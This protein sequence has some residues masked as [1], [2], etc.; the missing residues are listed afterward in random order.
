MKRRDFIRCLGSLALTM[1][2]S[3]PRAQTSSRMFRV[4]T[5]SPGI[6]MTESVYGPALVR[7]LAQHGY[8]VGRNLIIETRAAEGHLERIPA[9]I[10]DL[11]ANKVDVMVVQGYPPALAA[12]QIGTLPTVVL[13]GTGDPV[14]T[15]LIASLARPGGNIT[16]ISDVS[17]QLSPK[18]LELLKDLIPTL[19]QVA[20][21][22]NA[23]D[24]GMTLRVRESEQAARALN[25]SVQ[26]LGVREP[27]DFAAAFAAMI[28][29]LPDGILMV[30][31][32]LTLLNRRRV[33]EFSAAHRLPAIYE[34]EA[35]VRDGGLM[36]YGPDQSGSAE[37]GAALVD[38]IL[39][40]ASPAELPFENPTRFIFAI[41]LKTAK[42]LGITVPSTLLVQADVLIE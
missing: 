6:P 4:G 2:S 40:G 1:G 9:L 41:N 3:G 18:R 23:N 24:L 37:R 16:G 14:A 17:A 8:I 33:F 35:L 29:Q 20:M 15:G 12:K 10:H 36:S 28:D 31:D 38:R 19:K 5:L 13:G 22:W 21:L 39:R 32:S 26:A 42:S 7:G 11:I 30:S 34:F 25:L 27:N